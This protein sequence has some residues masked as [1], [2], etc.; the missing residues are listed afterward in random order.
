M[1]NVCENLI[2][3]MGYSSV[4]PIVNLEGIRQGHVKNFGDFS[5]EQRDK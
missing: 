5:L 2:S 3:G 1:L 4:Q